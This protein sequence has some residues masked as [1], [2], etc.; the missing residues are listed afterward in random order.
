[1]KRIL[2]QYSA[3]S[4]QTQVKDGYQADIEPSGALMGEGDSGFLDT[5][6]ELRKGGYK[7]WLISENFYDRG[8]VG[9]LDDDPK[10]LMEKDFQVLK[11]IAW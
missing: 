3:Y 5:I 10:A 9:K 1:M 6:A 8:P 11:K 2:G 4:P 7:G